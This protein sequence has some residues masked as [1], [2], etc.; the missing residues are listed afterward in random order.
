MLRCKRGRSR[1]TRDRYR[2]RSAV[3]CSYELSIV[4]SA[5]LLLVLGSLFRLLLS[6]CRG[7]IELSRGGRQTWSVI[8]F[9]SCIVIFVLCSSAL[10]ATTADSATALL[11]SA[12]AVESA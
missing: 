1:F 6:Q 5:S 3:Q 11:A 12:A 8:L 4:S 10:L 9:A 2:T 7:Q